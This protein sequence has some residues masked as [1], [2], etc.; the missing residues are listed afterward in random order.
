VDRRDFHKAALAGAAG[1]L[2]AGLDETAAAFPAPSPPVPDP[3]DTL[4]PG[5]RVRLGSNRF[6]H[7]AEQGNHGVNDLAFS[8][9]GRTL[10]ALGYQDDCISL[11]EV[12]SG[13]LLRKWEADRAD[14]CGE[15]AFS[16][17]GRFLAV[18]SNDGLRLW[19]PHAGRLVRT[20]TNE[21]TG[22]YGIAFAPDGR[23]LAAATAFDGAIDLWDVARGERV[24]R[25]QAD[26]NPVWPQVHYEK[27]DWFHSVAFSPDGT[28]LAAGSNY[29][30]YHDVHGEEAAALKNRLLAKYGHAGMRGHGDEIYVTEDRGR[31]WCWELASGRR[32]AKLEG[33][34]FPVERVRFI[35]DGRLVSCG[36]DGVVWVWDVRAGRRVGE[37]GESFGRVYQASAAFA[38]DGRHAVLSRPGYLGLIDLTDGHE[39]RQFAVGTDWGGWRDLAV[40]PDAHWVATDSRGRISL[41]DAAT[42]A[43][44]SPADRHT[45]WVTAVRF[46]ADGRRVVTVADD[47]AVLWGAAAGRR[48]GRITVDGR[49]MAPP[50]ALSRDGRCAASV[51][52]RWPD[53][54]TVVDCL[55]TWDWETGEVRTWGDPGVTAVAWG[56]HPESL[57]FGTEQGEVYVLDLPTGRRDRILE[58]V[59]GGVQDVAVSPDGRLAAALGKGPKVFVGE[60]SPEGWRNR[61]TISGLPK[62]GPHHYG[63]LGR[64]SF[65]P[66]GR[67]IALAAVHGC[68]CLGPVDGRALPLVFTA[69]N[70]PA[71]SVVAFAAGFLPDGRLLAAGSAGTARGGE[72]EGSEPPY[73][74]WVWD[75]ATG[76]E[77]WASPPQRHPIA[78]L[79]FSPDGR[80]LASGGDATA[81]LWGL[82]GP[83]Q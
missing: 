83:D 34:E 29:E 49:L 28:L 41:W 65:S 40:S 44:A 58:R 61:L 62:P 51:H 21:G 66:D 17:C 76:R 57:V 63:P 37:F 56:P 11:W 39:V 60:L 2:L 5:A 16:P 38:A 59:K 47:E 78:D 67:R 27:S 33:H 13:R 7:L 46:T 54:S 74:A 10:A 81:L 64:L 31:V 70:L 3:G 50:L 72:D 55:A 23:L 18:G 69:P 45:D 53:D 15:L 68:V 12:P 20:F 14:R 6:W 35:R 19:D 73:T 80:T 26:P 22:V 30:L 77:L 79:A 1:G 36:K 4:P 82:A 24:A 52:R 8:P 42:G 25:F 71:G 48:L 9:D 32:V 75:V 43:D